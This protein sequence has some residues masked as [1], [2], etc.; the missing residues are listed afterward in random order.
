M[1]SSSWKKYLGEGFLIVFSVL[2][3][4]FINKLAEDQK[5]SNKKQVALESIEKELDDNATILKEWKEQHTDIRERIGAIIEGKNDSLKNEL[6]KYPYLN[7]GVLTDGE[8]LIGE[9]LTSTAWEAAK[10]T[11]IISEFDFKTT[12]KLTRVYTLQSLLIDRTLTNML[13]YYFETGA[14]EMSNLEAILIQF[15]LRFW[16]LTGQEYLLEQ[17]Y[18]EALAELE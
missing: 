5:T 15:Q 16:E 18:Q 8:S 9:I 7:L 3:A 11:G 13:D 1:K 6:L 2:F 10:T 17:L 12:Q 14:H 4:L